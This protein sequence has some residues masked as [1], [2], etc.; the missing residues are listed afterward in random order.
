MYHPDYSAEE[1]RVGCNLKLEFDLPKKY[2]DRMQVFVMRAETRGRMGLQPG[3][4]LNFTA[5]YQAPDQPYAEHTENY[6]GQLYGDMSHWVFDETMHWRR[7]GC[8]QP[9]DYNWGLTYESE[10]V[11]GGEGAS[12]FTLGGHNYYGF[13]VTFDLF[14]VYC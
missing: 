9:E 6:V 1:V 4:Q 10:M 8:P 2:Q 11:L 3:G 12:T 14:W 13:D 7:P 5:G